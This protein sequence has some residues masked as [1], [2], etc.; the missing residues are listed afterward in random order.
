MGVYQFCDR[1]PVLS[2]FVLKLLKVEQTEKG[3][4]ISFNDFLGLSFKNS[5]SGRAANIFFDVFEQ[6]WTIYLL[7]YGLFTF[8]L[9]SSLQSVVHK[10]LVGR[11]I[12]N[13]V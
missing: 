13:L 6:M 8:A 5:L 9:L 12:S 10:P 1:E 11:L 7:D 3:L 2:K 4:Y